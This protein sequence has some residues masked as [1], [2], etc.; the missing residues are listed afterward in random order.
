[1]FSIDLREIENLAKDLDRFA[2]KAVP[3][4]T[5]DALN[6]S[7]FEGRRRW[8]EEQKRV[9]TTRN[10]W[11]T[12]QV[13]V[14]KAR[15]VNIRTMDAILGST[16]HFMDEREFGETKQRK[17]KHGVPIPTTHARGG[18]PK[19]LVR[20]PNRM[21]NIRLS[22]KSTG[23][24]SA[25]KQRAIAIR[26]AFKKGNKYTF[27]EDG[28]R[29]GIVRLMGSRKR[30]KFRTVWDLSKPSVRVKPMPTLGPALQR[31]EPALGPIWAQALIQQAKRHRIPG[32]R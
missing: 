31:L 20:R 15:G 21:P 19:R 28:R 30:V 10:T 18:S 2:R 29:K 16:A 27:L 22:K 23:G 32:Y 12:R 7:A 4:A 13:R 17:G 1:M 11:T 6:A 14:E 8:I 26:Q 9:F 25:K 5:R 24:G 3:H